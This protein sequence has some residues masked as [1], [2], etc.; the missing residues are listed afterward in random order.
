MAVHMIVLTGQ[1]DVLS[2]RIQEKYPNSYE[3]TQTCHLVHSE[4]ISQKI[5]I[6]IGIKGENRIADAAGAVFRLNRGAYSGY[7]DRAM[8]EWLNQAEE[9]E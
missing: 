3:I 1:N 7:A 9:L 8:W 2:A 5:A 6:A 4:D